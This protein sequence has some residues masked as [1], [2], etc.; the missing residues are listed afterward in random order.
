MSYALEA[1]QGKR[2]KNHNLVVIR[3]DWLSEAS[4]LIGASNGCQIFVESFNT[5]SGIVRVRPQLCK[6]MDKR[7]LE[8]RG[9]GVF[10][11]RGRAMAYLGF[12]SSRVL[13]RT[14]GSMSVLDI[15]P[16]QELFLTYVD[17]AGKDEG[18]NNVYEPREWTLRPVRSPE[19][20]DF[21]ATG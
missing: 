14:F 20:G 17:V 16:G 7:A 2:G 9:T 6:Y 3:S 8:I 12:I 13:T 11:Y 1:L 21:G 4:G 18:G 15:H 5:E 19:D 10:F